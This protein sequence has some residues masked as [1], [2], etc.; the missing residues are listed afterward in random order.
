MTVSL[1]RLTAGAASASE[2]E[3]YLENAAAINPVEMA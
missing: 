1:V 2:G 3:I